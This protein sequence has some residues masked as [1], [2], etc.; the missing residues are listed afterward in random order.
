MSFFKNLFDFKKKIS[1]KTRIITGLVM[2]FLNTIIVYLFDLVF[3]LSDLRIDYYCF[4]FVGMTIFGFF[5]S[6]N[7]IKKDFN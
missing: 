6:G 4:Y 7:M 1:F 2:G 3:D 5:F